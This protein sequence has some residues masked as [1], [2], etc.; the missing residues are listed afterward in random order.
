[1]ATGSKDVHEFGA[2]VA[3]VLSKRKGAG[4]PSLR[5]ME[6]TSGVPISQISRMLRGIKPMTIDEFVAICRALSLSP[7]SVLREAEELLALTQIP[8]EHY[9]PAP[10]PDDYTLSAQEGDAGAQQE[11][12]QELP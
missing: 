4:G 10:S 9:V 7:V 8:E 12:A 11:A 3:K 1:M 6:L 5:K 2:A